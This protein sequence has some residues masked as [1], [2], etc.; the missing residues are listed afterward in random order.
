MSTHGNT[1]FTDEHR[2]KARRVF[3]EEGKTPD[4]VAEVIG[5]SSR[6]V[7]TW[8]KEG[9]W[10]DARETWLQ[11]HDIPL[12]DLEERALR[13]LMGRLDREGDDLQIPELLNLLGN[14]NKF[15]LMIAKRKGYRLMDAALVVGEEFQAFVLRE[16]PA[17]AQAL[18][19][20]WKAFLDELQRR[21]E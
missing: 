7:Q 14:V 5:C 21:A 10:R 15:K 20:A 9:H 8:I 3:V 1:R 19:E 11:V 17:E 6:T 18:L 4:Q 16:C 12:E 2:A 13:R